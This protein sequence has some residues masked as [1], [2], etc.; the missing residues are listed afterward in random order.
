VRSSICS[1]DANVTVSMRPL[2][3]SP[4]NLASTGAPPRRDHNCPL[5]AQ[6]KPSCCIDGEASKFQVTSFVF[7]QVCRLTGQFS[8]GLRDRQ[9]SFPKPPIPFD[10]S[11]CVPFGFQQLNL[12]LK[13]TSALRN[14]SDDP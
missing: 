11:G 8:L 2:P 9:G 14:Y 10:N 6:L 1:G 4:S 13:T 5:F 7:I 3:N 12:T